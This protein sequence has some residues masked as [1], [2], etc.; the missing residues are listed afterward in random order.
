MKLALSTWNGLVAPLFDVSEKVTVAHISPCKILSRDL[1]DISRLECT[2]KIGR[3][4]ALN[5]DVLICGAISR[6]CYDFFPGWEIRIV[7]FV[8][9]PVEQIF[10]AL[11]YRKIFAWIYEPVCPEYMLTRNKE[12]MLWLADAL[13]E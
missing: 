2:A 4:S 11:L 13:G 3:L 10:E 6:I 9:G 8:S 7:A 12:T 1:V 5:I